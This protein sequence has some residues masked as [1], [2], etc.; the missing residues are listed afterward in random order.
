MVRQCAPKS[1]VLVHG[2]RSRMEF[3]RDKIERSNNIQSESQRDSVPMPVS[4]VLKLQPQSSG[5]GHVQHM[6]PLS[7]ASLLTPEEALST[8]GLA[9][10]SIRFSAHCSLHPCWLK[11]GS[12]VVLEE[13]EEDGLLLSSGVGV[14]DEEEEVLHGSGAKVQHPSAEEGDGPGGEIDGLCRARSALLCRFPLLSI[15]Q[16]QQGGGVASFA[17]RTVQISVPLRLTGTLGAVLK[18]SWDVQ[19]EGLAAS[20]MSVLSN[21]SASRPP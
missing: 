12:G 7:A 14:G 16:V 6:V 15:G 8:L 11:Q 17:C 21:P 5:Q 4:S 19:D 3:M 13:E 10:Y 20:F 18:C 1:V 2:E 9:P